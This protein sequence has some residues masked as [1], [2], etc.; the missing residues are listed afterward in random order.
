MKEN[1]LHTPEKETILSSKADH[2][3]NIL[4][5]MVQY[6]VNQSICS[7]DMQ[8]YN[9]WNLSPFISTP[10]SPSTQPLVVV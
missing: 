1:I 5:N 6:K 2:Y 9:S 4:E 7:Q 10:H 3:A 8:K